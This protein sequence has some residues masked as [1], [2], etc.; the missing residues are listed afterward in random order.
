M[1]EQEIDAEVSRYAPG[2]S[3]WWR[4]F[5]GTPEEWDVCP[6]DVPE[7]TFD[8]LTGGTLRGGSLRLYP[9]REAAYADLRQ[10]IRATGTVAAR[11]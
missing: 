1:S 10:A 2:H 9:T 3:T 5:R 7:A 11:H 8:A 6:S 4:W